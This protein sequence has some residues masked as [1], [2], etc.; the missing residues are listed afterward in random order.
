M[1][2]EEPAFLEYKYIM[3]FMFT[4][5]IVPSLSY[6]SIKIRKMVKYR[7]DLIT[8]K[9]EKLRKDEYRHILFILHTLYIQILA[10]ENRITELFV[11][12]EKCFEI[13]RYWRCEY[14]FVNVITIMGRFHNDEIISKAQKYLKNMTRNVFSSINYESE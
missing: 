12:L 6:R 7:I 9:H 2:I 11:A 13:V 4:L 3:K 5:Y 10:S 8:R 1:L 14:L